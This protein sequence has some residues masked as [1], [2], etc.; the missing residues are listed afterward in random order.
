MLVGKSVRTLNVLMGIARGCWILSYQ[1]VS[2]ALVVCFEMRCSLDPLI[3]GVDM[4]SDTYTSVRQSGR[5]QVS[6]RAEEVI[7]PQPH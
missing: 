6:L 2:L 1:W 5:H 3:C 7:L 4:S